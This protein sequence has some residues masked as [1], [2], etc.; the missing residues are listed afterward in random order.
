M[1]C[2]LHIDSRMEIKSYQARKNLSILTNLSLDMA[3]KIQITPL[4]G[5]QIYTK[6]FKKFTKV[7]R[8]KYFDR[9]LIVLDSDR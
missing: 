1:E 8:E 7:T 9:L 2:G 4:S 6:K 5:Y 3:P